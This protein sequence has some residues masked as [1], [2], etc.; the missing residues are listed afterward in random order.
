MLETKLQNCLLNPG[1]FPEKYTQNIRLV[2]L[3][4]IIFCVY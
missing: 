1:P 3:H 4:V 2:N